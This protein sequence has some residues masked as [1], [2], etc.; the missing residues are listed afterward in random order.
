M[1]EQLIV[2]HRIAIACS[3]G[4]CRKP[5]AYV[6]LNSDGRLSVEV[7]NRHSGELHRTIIDVEAVMSRLAPGE[8]NGQT[9]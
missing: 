1:T 6:V 5:A 4:E 9:N 7:R 3:C 8:D 2:T